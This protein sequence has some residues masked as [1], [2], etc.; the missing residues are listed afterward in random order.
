[1]LEDEHLL[2]ESCKGSLAAFELIIQ[3]WDKRMLAYFYRCTSSVEDA[4]DLRQ[5]LFLRVYQSR[6]RFQPNGSFS[7]WIYTIASNLVIDK[8]A[9]KKTIPTKHIEEA[10]LNIQEPHGQSIPSARHE[11][12]NGKLQE[13]LH[14]ALQQ[15]PTE[16]RL[17][18][19]MRH[20]EELTFVQIAQILDTSEST[21][22]TRVYRGLVAL[23]KELKRNGILESDC[24]QTV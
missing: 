9:R 15:L 18:L 6:K 8:V 1:M 19:V 5:E 7:A 13:Y 22:K 14:A 10:E 3:R 4:K 2:V 12:Q 16:Q 20:M 21:V 11:M 23:K 17:A 24:L